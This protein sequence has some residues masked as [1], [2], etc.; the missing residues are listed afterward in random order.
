M[1][2]EFLMNS[3]REINIKDIYLNFDNSYL[4]IFSIV[5]IIIVRCNILNYRGFPLNLLKANYCTIR[6]FQVIDV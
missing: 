4:I 2:I 6:N 3:L 1:K 5:P